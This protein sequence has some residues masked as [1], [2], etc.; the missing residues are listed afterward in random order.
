MAVRARAR[1]SG[2]GLIAAMITPRP[3]YW[4]GVVSQTALF[5]VLHG[6]GLTLAL[7]F[8]PRHRIALCCALGLPMTH[9]S[10]QDVR[11]EIAAAMSQ[12]ER[13]AELAQLGFARPVAAKHWLQ[14]SNPSERWKW[15]FMV[16]DLPPIKFAGKPATPSLGGI[17]V[18]EVE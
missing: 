10:S 1:R 4:R 15:D 2:M 5:L 7:G 3:C 16:Q 11:A 8:G 17:P 12:N 18:T 13:Y 6:V 14:A 9:S